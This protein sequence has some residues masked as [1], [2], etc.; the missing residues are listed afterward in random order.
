M[1]KKHKH[2]DVIKAWADGETIQLKGNE[3]EVWKDVTNPSWSVY[4]EYRVKPNPTTKWYRVSLFKTGNDVYFG[5]V[6]ENDYLEKNY[7]THS[8]FIRW[9]TDRQYVEV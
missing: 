9:V 1:T 7:E 4:L 2:C 3:P 6:S 8:D 5:F